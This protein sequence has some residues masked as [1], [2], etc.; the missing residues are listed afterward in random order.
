MIQMQTD[1]ELYS[2]L[3]K[4]NSQAL[5][6]LYNRYGSLV[7]TLALTM[8]KDSQ[9][10]EDLTQEIFLL[11]WNR[12]AYNPQRSS[13]SSYLTTVTR[14]RAIDRLR[15]RSAKYRLLSRCGQIMPSKFHNNPFE[16]ASM[17]E[18]REQV[19]QSLNQLPENHRKVLELAYY[20]GLSQTEIASQL[21]KPL[22]TVKTWARKGLLQLRNNLQELD[23]GRKSNNK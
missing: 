7:Y 15:S 12:Q 16:E 10:A 1:I 14:S 19:Q 6:L 22:G 8:L 20:Q 4:G 9:E 17:A 23:F 21:G 18:R 2:A 5:E 3:Q 11:L 13:L